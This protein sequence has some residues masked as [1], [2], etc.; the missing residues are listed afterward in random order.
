MFCMKS[1]WKLR[2]IQNAVHAPLPEQPMLS[3]CS[4]SWIGCQFTSGFNSRCWFLTFK[5]LHGIGSGYLR[6]HHL[7]PRSPWADRKACYGNHLWVTYIWWISKGGSSLPPPYEAS[8]ASQV[9]LAI[10]L[11]R[12][13][14]SLETWLWPYKFDKFPIKVVN[15][16][17]STNSNSFTNIFLW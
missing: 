6:D 2:L 7:S 11:L 5:V 16:N 9:R 4:M 17:F 15:F 1:I 13:Q 8:P 3:L 12:I 10:S 14:K